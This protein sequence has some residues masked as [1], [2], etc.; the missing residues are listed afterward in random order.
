M[1][2]M[3]NEI[4]QILSSYPGYTVSINGDNIEITGGSGVTQIITLEKQTPDNPWIVSGITQL[5]TTYLFKFKHGDEFDTSGFTG[6]YWD[7]CQL[8]GKF[9][10]D[11]NVYTTLAITPGKGGDIK[12]RRGGKVVSIG[13]VKNANVK[14]G[15]NLYETTFELTS[16]FYVTDFY[17]DDR[18]FF[19]GDQIA[20]GMDGLYGIMDSY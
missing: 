20:D 8:K 14:L 1:T 10:G 15:K 17:Y 7:I 11:P 2:A 16:S 3:K 12:V 4:N 13:R 5:P 9:V 6:E 19:G 18:D